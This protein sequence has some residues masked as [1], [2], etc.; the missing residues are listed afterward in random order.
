MVKK[1]ADIPL[2]LQG[3]DHKHLVG[4]HIGPEDREDIIMFKSFHDFD[5]IYSKLDIYE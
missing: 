1:R 4:I 3:T 5:L 2:R